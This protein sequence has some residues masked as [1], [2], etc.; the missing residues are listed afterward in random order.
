[1]KLLM[2]LFMLSMAFA[3][4]QD[5]GTSPASKWYEKIQL[6]GYA[7]FRYNRLLETNKDLTCSTC[8]KS[9]GDKQGFFLRRARLAF[10]GQVHDRIYINIQP[11]YGTD[12]A[13]ASSSGIAST[14]QN[15]LNIRDAYFDYALTE[16]KEWRLRTGI[17]KIP[18]GWENMQ[19]S[20]NR[21]A[22][23]RSD[24]INTG[25]PNERDIGIFTI[26]SPSEIRERFRE[27]TSKNLKGTGDYGLFAFGVYNGQ[28]INRP[29][30]NN[31]LHRAIRLTYPYK[32]SGGQFIEASLQAYEGKFNASDD[33]DYYDARWASTFV[34]YPQPLGLQV[35]YNEGQGPE[36]DRRQNIIRTDDLKGGYAQV[37]Y[38]YQFKSQLLFPYVR[39]QEYSGGRKIENGAP[40]IKTR[41]WELGSEWQ[42][43]SAFELT[44]AYAMSDRQTQSSL[45]NRSHEKGQL[46]RLQAQFNY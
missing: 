14:Q 25:I 9:L 40:D 19:S 1:M 32:L 46:L 7:Q 16:E 18:F 21:L 11:D 31:D 6:R 10:F 13:T 23:D 15:Y 8:D 20:S 2:I 41:E 36:Y 5:Q 12:A 39:F 17:Q 37:N 27:L 42:P 34:I 28:S 43:N 24:A 35:E 3:H 26:Y 45:T 44:V 38:M 33:S 30:K 29:E 22:F 4:S